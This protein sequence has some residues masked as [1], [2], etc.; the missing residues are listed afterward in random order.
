MKTKDA[1]TDWSKSEKT[2]RKQSKF[3]TFLYLMLNTVPK[4]IA[5]LY[6]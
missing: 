5:Y 3:S 4:L 6:C 1:R 2:F